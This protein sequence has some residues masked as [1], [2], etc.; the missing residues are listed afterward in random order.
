M[1]AGTL[2]FPDDQALLA[3]IKHRVEEGGATG[4][5]LGV[6]DADGTRRI[7]AYGDP[8]PGARPLG[9]ESVF[10]IGS[11]TKAFTGILLAEMAARGEVDLE[12][13]AQR[14]APTGLSL[15]TRGGREITL[16]DLASHRSSLPR[17]P[18]N[19]MLDDPTNPIPSFRSRRCT[20]F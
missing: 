8:G 11:I 20:N 1:N 3:L 10:E 12:A 19:L 14:Y 15:P 4:I 16:T 9:P 2:H 18:G 6:L 5:V 17:L 7:V 13:P